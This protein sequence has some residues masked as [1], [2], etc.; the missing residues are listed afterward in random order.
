MPEF[1]GH[2]RV[3][4]LGCPVDLLS[5]DETVHL[6]EQA[7][8]EQRPLHHVAINVAKLVNMRSD[9]ELSADVRCADIAGIDGMGVVLGL[10]LLG[11]GR[12]KRVAGVD[13][14][15]EILA[16]CAQ[17][18]Y[19][20]YFL[21]ATPEVVAEAARRMCLRFPG[22]Q[23]AGMRDGY[24]KPHEEAQIA[25]E[26]R[27]CKP[28]CLFVAM[29]TPRKER[30]LALHRHEL[31]VA[32]VMGV[33]GSFDILAGK[34]NRAPLFMQQAGLEWLYRIYQE[35]QRM[36]WRYAKTNTIFAWLLLG[37]LVRQT[38]HPVAGARNSTGHT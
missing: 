37:Q 24:F 29:P 26:I 2:L 9:A 31:G 36:W 3:E 33:G 21:G 23:L 14:M 22:L 13:L 27:A 5:G 11:Y 1:P 32:F 28:D 30:F 16:V 6:I 12:N 10:R 15:Q 25:R 4:L 18:G 19:R 7:M 17:R 35:P 34:T 38:T 8:R 20:P